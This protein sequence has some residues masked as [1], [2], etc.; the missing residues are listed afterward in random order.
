MPMIDLAEPL[1]ATLH[2]F[3]QDAV[4]NGGPATL[5]VIL[6]TAVADELTG[7]MIDHTGPVAV[8]AQNEVRATGLVQGDRLIV[9]DVDYLVL[10]IHADSLGGMIIRLGVAPI[11][12]A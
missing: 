7:G 3:G 12:G 6:D 2:D 1:R 10:A 9:G 4:V 8:A 5:R 11:A